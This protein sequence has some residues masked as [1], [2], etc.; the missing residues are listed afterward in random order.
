[1]AQEERRMT[2]IVVPH[3]GGDLSTRS[4]EVSYRRLRVAALAALAAV[5][6][7]VGMAVSYGWVAAQAAR[8]PGLQAEIRQLQAER[9]RVLQ[10]AE[11]VARLERSYEQVRAMLG[12]TRPGADSATLYLP[13]AAAPEAAPE[14][15][16]DSP[17]RAGVPR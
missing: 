8:V 6:L 4:F 9:R 1:M 14:A 17:P 5:L 15:V 16:P 13:P 12:A 7:W 11:E 2:F 3:G 10:L